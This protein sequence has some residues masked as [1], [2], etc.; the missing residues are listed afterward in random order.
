MA[1]NTRL[2]PVVVGDQVY[3]Q[4]Q[5]QVRDREVVPSD[6]LIKVGIGTA[7]IILSGGKAA[8]LPVPP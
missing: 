8:P 7:I 5:L 2:E 3:Q 4:H 6:V 1:R